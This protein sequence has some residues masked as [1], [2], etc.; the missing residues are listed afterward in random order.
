MN[1]FKKWLVAIMFVVSIGGS[2]GV[3]AMPQTAAAAGCTGLFTFPQWYRGIVDAKCEII[4]PQTSDDVKRYIFTVA[5]NVIEIAL[6]LV[7]YISVGFIIYGG[8]LYIIGAG[9]A[10]KMVSARKTILNAVI[11]LVISFFSVVIVNVIVSRF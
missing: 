4:P 2:F 10:D 9:A 1:I 11:G 7:G 6:Q 3:V 5:L 8:Y